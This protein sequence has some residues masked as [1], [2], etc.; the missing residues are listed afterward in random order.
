MHLAMKETCVFPARIFSPRDLRLKRK[1]NKKTN[2][3]QNISLTLP[4]K[5]TDGSR[6]TPVSN[7]VPPLSGI[8]YVL[9]LGEKANKAI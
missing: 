1:D 7:G 2:Q 4:F 9:S 5:L 3:S 6:S 8:S